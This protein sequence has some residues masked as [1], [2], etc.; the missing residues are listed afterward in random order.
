MRLQVRILIFHRMKIQ[1]ISH[2]IKKENLYLFEGIHGETSLDPSLRFNPFFF[3]FSSLQLQLL[4]KSALN[5]IHVHCSWVPQTS[6]FSNF[7]IKNGFHSTIHTFKNYF[8]TVFS[9]FSFNKI[10][11]I[12]TDLRTINNMDVALLIKTSLA[13]L[14]LSKPPKPQ[15]YTLGALG[16]LPIYLSNQTTVYFSYHQFMHKLSTPS[17]NSK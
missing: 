5:S 14:Q 16:E 12:Q 11:S 6:L 15:P 10:S 1:D 17:L 7:F 8:T 4:T 13:S 2:L 3:F 9:V